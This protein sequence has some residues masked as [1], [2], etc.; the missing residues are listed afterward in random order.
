MLIGGE[1]LSGNGAQ[2]AL[3]SNYAAVCETLGCEVTP[4][5]GNYL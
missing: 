1:L 5:R 4:S 3:V 2:P